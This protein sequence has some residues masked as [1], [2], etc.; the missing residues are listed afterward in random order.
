MTLHRPSNVDERDT[1]SELVETLV[2]LSRELRVVFAVHPRTRKRL[3][4]FG[5]LERIA[6]AAGIR[7][8]SP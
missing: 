8:P 7:S 2:A 3:E 1:L 5:L 6:G 4:E